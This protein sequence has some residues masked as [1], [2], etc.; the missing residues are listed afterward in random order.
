MVE[1]RMEIYISRK[2]KVEKIMEFVERIKKFQEEAGIVLRKAQKE[3]KL[4]VDMGRKKVEE[5]KKSNKIILNMKNLVFKKWLAN[6]LVNQYFGLYIM[7]KIIFT[8]TIILQLLIS[9]RINS[10][11]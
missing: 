1:L 6:K 11:S 3:M 7:D 2:R 9:M 8:N 4:Q 5:W 10:V